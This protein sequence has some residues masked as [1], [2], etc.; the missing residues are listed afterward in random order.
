MPISAAGTSTRPRVFPD[1]CCGGFSLLELL[2]VATIIAVFAGVAVLSLGTLGSDRVLQREAAR[3]QGLIDLLTEEAVLESR[4]YGLLFSET[5]YRFYVF[6][7][8]T[9]TWLEPVGDRLLAERTLEEPLQLSLELDDREVRLAQDF[10]T[11]DINEQP[12]PQVIVF[13]SGEVTPFEVGFFRE[14]NAGR[15]VL[16]AEFNGATSV[17]GDGFDPI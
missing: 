17:V 10:D 8:Q 9:F 7:Y 16:S 13:G 3:L 15:F 11:M 2:V 6:D 5:G 14:L 1:G 12:E 4:D